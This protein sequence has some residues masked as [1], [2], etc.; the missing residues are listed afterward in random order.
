MLGNF[1]AQLN[2]STKNKVFF[3]M[4]LKNYNFFNVLEQIQQNK[5]PRDI[6]IQKR[7][8]RGVMKRV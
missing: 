3:V 7:E 6:L 5:H 1:Y 2:L 8:R 4:R